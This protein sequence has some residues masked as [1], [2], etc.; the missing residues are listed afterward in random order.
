MP[1]ISTAG[2]DVGSM[3]SSSALG[4]SLIPDLR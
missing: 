2:A 1:R 4:R 3:R